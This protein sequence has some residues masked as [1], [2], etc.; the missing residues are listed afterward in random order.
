MDEPM[1]PISIRVLGALIEKEKTT[2]DNYPLTLNSL[3]AACNQT[4]NRDPV[5][6]LEEGTVAIS[7]DDLSKRSLAREVHRSDSRAKRYRQTMSETLHLHPAEMAVLCVLMLRGVQTPGEIRGRTTR[8]FDFRDVPHVEVTLDALMTLSPPLVVKLERRPG[9]KEERYA[10]LLAGEPVAM[11]EEP[12]GTAGEERTDRSGESR[13][14]AKSRI[15][16]LEESVDALREELA[17]LRARF[18]EFRREFQ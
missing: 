17:E 13:P 9:Q 10:H 7:L 16:S 4:S 12:Y 5:M 18:E 15:E 8:L 1:D 14:H 6:T 3:V 2:P 11:A